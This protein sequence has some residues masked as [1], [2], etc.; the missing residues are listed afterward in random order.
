MPS[1]GGGCG[2]VGGE[3]VQLAGVS[4]LQGRREPAAAVVTVHCFLGLVEATEFSA[5]GAQ[6][7]EEVEEVADICRE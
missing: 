1:P 4:G 5:P 3:V 2:R 6:L 7:A